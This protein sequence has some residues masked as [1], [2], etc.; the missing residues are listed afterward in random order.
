LPAQEVLQKTMNQHYESFG[1]TNKLEYNRLISKYTHGNL[2]INVDLFDKLNESVI[3]QL[4][5]I[6]SRH[7]CFDLY[8]DS[9]LLNDSIAFN[10]FNDLQQFLVLLYDESE[11]NLCIKILEDYNEVRRNPSVDKLIL[12][13]R[14]ICLV[15]SD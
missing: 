9:I 8:H 12:N 1:Q 13:L 11:Y 15:S 14:W 3:Y 5:A 7:K 2:D 10:D 4:H 6:E